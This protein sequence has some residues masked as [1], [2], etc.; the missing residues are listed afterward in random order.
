MFNV[1]QPMQFG[2]QQPTD[3][4]SPE[5]AAKQQDEQTKISQI[6]SKY[7]KLCGC[8]FCSNPTSADAVLAKVK[9]ES[10]AHIMGHEQAHK[11]AA[12][13][14]GGGIH[15]EYDGNGVAV[16]GHVPI[17][18]PKLDSQDPE[19]ALKAYSTIRGAALAP[20]DPSGQD[21]SVAS[22]AQSLMGQ[23]KVLMDQKKL[24]QKQGKPLDALP[25]G[26]ANP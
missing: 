16:A 13:G 1:Q 25:M 17:S 3:S 14:F 6:Q 18:I 11:S 2:R 20:S 12:G 9:A 7:A 8:S 21:M 4:R 5:N 24:A 19:G 26:K 10:F 23:A 22:M 15:I